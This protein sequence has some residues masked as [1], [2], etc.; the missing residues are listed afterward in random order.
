MV[1]RFADGRG[2]FYGDNVNGG[3]SV[4]MGFIWM[5][6]ESPRWEQRDI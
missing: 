4:H 6:E 3:V 1:G 5:A 2:E